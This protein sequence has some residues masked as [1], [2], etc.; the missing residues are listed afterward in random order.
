M[1][2]DL[3]K[4]AP[5]PPRSSFPSDRHGTRGCYVQGCHCDA[6]RE[7]NKLYNRKNTREKIWKGGNPLVSTEASRAHLL[8]LAAEGVGT[9]LVADLAKV[10]RTVLAGIRDGSRPNVRKR[11]EERIL[12]VT[13]DVRFLTDA[14]LVDGKPTMK[15]LKQM[16]RWG[17]PKAEIARRLGSTA[18]NPALQ[19]KE[20]LVTNA[21]KVKVEKL[22]AA[23]VLE[24]EAAEQA[25]QERLKAER[26]A[27]RQ[28]ARDASR[29]ILLD[30]T[31]ERPDP[32][33]PNIDWRPAWSN[34]PAKPSV[35]NHQPHKAQP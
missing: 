27:A 14:L 19:I 22:Y 6:C 9:R 35:P 7:A 17:M 11:V 32:P 12:A 15:L 23:A 26:A 16:L 4:R 30:A 2:E 33:I 20:G 29:R 21:N 28:E 24:R 13:P 18:K 1:T 3:P 5:R 31:P 34:P 10:S 8:M 25:E